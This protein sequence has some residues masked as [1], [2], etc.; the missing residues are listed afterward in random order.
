MERGASLSNCGHLDSIYTAYMKVA[1][2]EELK[3]VSDC[4]RLSHA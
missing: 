1:V 4:T 3:L 2:G